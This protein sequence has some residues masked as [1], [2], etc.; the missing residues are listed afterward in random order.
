MYVKIQF[1]VLLT[2]TS[3]FFNVTEKVKMKLGSVGYSEF[4]S[5][6]YLKS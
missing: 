6:V 4:H 3:F 5:E 1:T 2:L